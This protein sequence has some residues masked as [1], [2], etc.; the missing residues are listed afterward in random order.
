MSLVILL[1]QF[2][3]QISLLLVHTLPC[4]LMLCFLDRQQRQTM[5]ADFRDL[6][7]EWSAELYVQLT[8]PV[9]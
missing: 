8:L 4:T 6:L 9:C 2:K 3:E 1:T 5:A 7:F